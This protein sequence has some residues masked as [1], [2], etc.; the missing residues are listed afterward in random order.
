MDL[1]VRSRRAVGPM[2]F[3][4]M[5][6]ASITSPIV[7]GSGAI[8]NG[9]ALAPFIRSA[10]IGRAD[11]VMIGD[12]NQVRGGH[13][14]DHGVAKAYAET[15]GVYA[16]GLLSAGENNGW[17]SASGFQ[18]RVSSTA[19]SECCTYDDAPVELDRVMSA[20]VEM[21][22]LNFMFIDSGS[23]GATINMGLVI[24]SDAA[25]DVNA[26]LRF[27][28]IYGEFAGNAGR[29]QP[30]VRKNQWPWTELVRGDPVLTGGAEFGVGQATLDLPAGLRGFGL[31]LRFTPWG[32]DMTGP[33]L[34]FYVRAENL[35]RATGTASQSL[36]AFG[37]H[38]ARDMASAFQQADDS[39]LSLY[40]QNIRA[41]Q[42]PDKAVLVRI[43]SG[44]NDRNE[45]APS[46]GP[47]GITDG[48][49]PEAFADN[50][51]AIM[52]R[53]ESIWVINNWDLNEL[54]FLCAV[55]HPVDNPDD[56]FLVGYRAATNNLSAQRPRMAVVDFSGL[57][58]SGEMLAN[59]WY[60]LNG[61]DRNHLTEPAYE[62]LARRELDAIMNAI[63]WADQ[64]GNGAVDFADITAVLSEWGTDY[65]SSPS[66]TGIGDADRNG[67][68]EFADI[69]EILSTWGQP[70]P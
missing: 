8:V 49:S 26:A 11:I 16:T 9:E 36:Y 4:T 23:I 39:Y 54:A 40:F 3:A 31:N 66:G 62:E 57:T 5:A 29:F 70:C 37:G 43:N 25:L 42:G 33:V 22:P 20:S 53:I 30:S 64:S 19:S 32:I 56:E 1:D 6:V 2:V 44:L 41:L 67:I 58:S 51:V 35:A 48:S 21:A 47:A 12:S 7:A 52:D 13:G 69:T 63:C 46:V 65:W 10:I 17:G 38:S 59:G 60:N 14:W 50:L 18:H 45:Q 24:D 15:F 55:S 34:L 68:V 28:L 61:L 27:H